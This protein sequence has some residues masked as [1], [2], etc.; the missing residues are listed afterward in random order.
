MKT[1]EV[2]S[3]VANEQNGLSRKTESSSLK[4]IGDK[5]DLKSEIKYLSNASVSR[6]D[7]LN[8]R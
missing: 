4:R 1:V 8:H 7:F 5:F 2:S 3:D 6:N